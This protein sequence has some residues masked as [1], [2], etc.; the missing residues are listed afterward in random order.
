MN[1]RVTGNGSDAGTLPCLQLK[2][3][4]NPLVAIVALGGVL[5]YTTA[6]RAISGQASIIAAGGFHTCALT[7]DG[8]LQ[9]WGE[10]SYGALGNGT[11]TNS[12]TPVAVS[13]PT[14]YTG[15]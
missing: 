2:G 13:G 14:A 11:A 4:V 6:A 9:C 8:A 1:K 3:L 5:G 15:H 7:S 10:N 12:S